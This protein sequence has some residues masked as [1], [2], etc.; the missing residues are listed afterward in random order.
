M[1]SCVIC[2][3]NAEM[4]EAVCA[5]IAQHIGVPHEII[6]IDN[7]ENSYSICQAYNKGAGSARFDILCFL[8]EDLL[9]ETNDWGKRLLEHFT[10][11]KDPGLIGLAGATYKAL[12]P[13]GWWAVTDNYL[14]YH[15]KQSYKHAQVATRERKMNCESVKEVICLDGVFL[16]VKKEVF[17]KFRFDESLPHFHGYDLDLSLAVASEYKNYVVPDILINH[18]SEGSLDE[19][20]IRN[21]YFL[22]KKWNSKLPKLISGEPDKKMESLVW[23]NYCRTTMASTLGFGMKM[24]MLFDTLRVMTKR[25]SSFWPVYG[26]FRSMA[27][28]LSVKLGFTKKPEVSS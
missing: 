12:A 13:S 8:H 26:F 10:A 22:F 21:M 18:L 23:Q 17:N 14:S 15:Y 28:H 16:A 27:Y 7:R 2:S 1:I 24:N 19:T 5:N 9:F 25:T 11:V 6:V 20:W 4:Q 3:T